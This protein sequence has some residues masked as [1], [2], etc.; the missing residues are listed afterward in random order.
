M[1][2]RSAGAFVIGYMAALK[3][4]ILSIFLSVV[5]THIKADADDDVQLLKSD[6]YDSVLLEQLRNKIGALG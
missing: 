6:G 4:F 1:D 2:R 5:L 3:L